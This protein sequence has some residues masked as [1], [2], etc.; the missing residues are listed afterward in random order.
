M[1][2]RDFKARAEELT[3]GYEEARDA[4]FNSQ[5]LDFILPPGGVKDCKAISFTEDDVQGFL[6]SFDFPEQWDW[7][8][9][10]VQS[11]LDDIGDQKYEQM[12]DERDE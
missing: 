12:R 7:A 8:Y 9:D 10:K 6:D 3:D 2:T 11:E 1:R 4:E 5:F